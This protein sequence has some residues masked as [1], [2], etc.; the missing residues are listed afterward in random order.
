L[1][2]PAFGVADLAGG[3]IEVEVEG[4]GEH[5]GARAAEDGEEGAVD[6]GEELAGLCTEAGEIL[7]ER[8]AGWR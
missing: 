4:G 2:W 6:M 8:S 3:G 1:G 5:G 7:D